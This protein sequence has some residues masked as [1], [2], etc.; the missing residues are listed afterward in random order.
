MGFRQCAIMS[1]LCFV[2]GAAYSMMRCPTCAAPQ[3]RPQHG[4]TV[5]LSSRMAVMSAAAADDEG[6]EPEQFRG[7]DDLPESRG[8]A[9]ALPWKADLETLAER[10][11]TVKQ[12]HELTQKFEALPSAWVLVFDAETDDEAVYSMQME[13]GDDGDEMHAVLAFEEEADAERYALSLTDE[14]YSSPATVQALDFEAL[15]VTSRDAEFGVAVVFKVRPC[16]APAT[17]YP[18]PCS[19]PCRPLHC[20]PHTTREVVRARRDAQGDLGGVPKVDERD[21][22]LFASDAAASLSVSITMVPDDLF[23]GKQASDYI[24]PAEDPICAPRR[25]RPGRAA[26]ALAAPPGPRRAQAEVPLSRLARAVWQHYRVPTAPF[27]ANFALCMARCAGPATP[28]LP[29]D[30]CRARLSHSVSCAPPSAGVLVHDAG[31]ADAQYFSMV[32]NGSDSI[33]CFRDEDSA[34][35][36]G[37]ALQGTGALRAPKT[38]E[39]LLEDLLNSIS[40]ERDVCLVDEVSALPPVRPPSP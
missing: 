8:S 4:H 11:K 31:T 17:A 3:R 1:A 19:S 13:G 9:E 6:A 35:R 14:P 26:A 24:D 25:R 36:C 18:A 30:S 5:K 38:Q 27:W 7:S 39:V 23:A 10:M 32:L 40:E 12:D 29:H 28:R 34:S 21:I 15:V 2:Q 16:P 33:V 37:E 22:P 20:R